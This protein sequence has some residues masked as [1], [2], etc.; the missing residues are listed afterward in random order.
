M[1]IIMLP[2]LVVQVVVPGVVVDQVQLLLDLLLNQEQT[3]YMVPQIMETLVELLP[4]Q[5]H[6][7]VVLVVEV[8][9]HLVETLI[10]PMSL[11]MVE[12]E[13]QTHMHM[14]PQIL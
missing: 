14:D 6:I 13:E 11:V 3:H 4:Q 9:V 1:I 10:L 7:G 2:H 5:L 12:M 8:L